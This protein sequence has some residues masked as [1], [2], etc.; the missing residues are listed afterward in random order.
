MVAWSGRYLGVTSEKRVRRAVTIYAD[1]HRFNRLRETL[2]SC[3][4]VFNEDGSACDYAGN[5]FTWLLGAADSEYDREV[6]RTFLRAAW[7]RAFFPGCNV[8]WVPIL[9]GPQGLGKSFLLRMLAFRDEWF[10]DAVRDASDPKELGEDVAG[11]YVVEFGEMRGLRGRD[12]EAVKAALSATADRFTPKYEPQNVE[13]PR[14][15]VMAGTTNRRDVLTDLTGNRRFYIVECGQEDPKVPVNAENQAECGRFIRAAYG[16]VRAEYIKACEAAGCAD[17][18]HPT[19]D[20]LGHMGPL[21]PP[22][23]LDAEADRLREGFSEADEAKDAIAEYVQG[24]EAGQRVCGL[25]VAKNALGLGA[26]EYAK[27]RRIQRRVN[28]ILANMP[29]LRPLGKVRV[30]GLGVRVAWARVED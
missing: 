21:T 3:E 13:R 20:V 22:R 18:M 1:C 17:T 28:H 7:C 25:L 27:D 5:V 23:G 2:L 11:R 10:T 6:C 29:T 8:P 30:E 24:L 26:D 9:H 15:Y 14:A 16:E 12:Q 19:R 4:Q